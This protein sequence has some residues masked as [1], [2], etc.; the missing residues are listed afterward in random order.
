MPRRL[1]PTAKSSFG[2]TNI[3]IASLSYKVVN[4]EIRNPKSERSPNPE[5][6]I[7]RFGGSILL[8]SGI[9]LLALLVASQCA[10]NRIFR[11]GAAMVDITPTNFPIRTAGNLRLT[12][13]DKAIDPLNVRA[14][15]LD[16]QRIQIAIAVVDSCMID[17]ETM[18]AA[19]SLAQRVTGI[20]VE[21]ML[22]SST[23]TH[24]APA[25]YSCHGN[26]V[27]LAYVQYLIPK[28]AET[29]VQAWRNRTNALVGWGEAD[30]PQ[31][32]HCRHWIMRPG[33]AD[34]PP[35]AFTGQRTNIAMM[36]P[37][38]ANTNKVRQTGVVDSS[39]TVLSLRTTDGRPLAL[40][41]NYS[42]HYAGVG[43]PG[44]SADYFGE[45]CRVIAKDLGTEE[46]K[47]FVALMSNGTSGD[48]NCIDFTKPDWKVD[49]FK[50]ART[51]ADAT[52]RALKEI[53]YYDWVPLGMIE[54]KQ[55]F[56]VRLP[57]PE[58]V[59]EAREFLARKV[60]DRP[61][62]NWEENYA[63]ETMNM[64]DWPRKK[65]VKL[66]AV[67]IGKLGIGTTPCETFGSTGLAIKRNSPFP[68][69]MVIELANGCNGYLPPPDE[70]E[71]GGYT[72]W[73]ARTSYLETGA[74]PEI[75]K[76]VESLLARLVYGKERLPRK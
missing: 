12:I 70:F 24:S 71:V 21:H 35:F 72:T 19:K 10:A 23:H 44:V 51:V 36:N 42:T 50:V 37:G 27:E 69:T 49:R 60:G 53:R 61:T 13:A 7:A 57:R 47:P 74:E 28:I 5:W 32:V 22:I 58:D 38:Y 8:R 33:T 67:C 54:K 25:A 3:F 34:N 63:R 68:V 17:R 16:N 56:K 1:Y 55:S 14:L 48:A 41:A 31:F 75:R 20:P 62:R 9:V 65:E 26:D 45:F 40:L 15:V 6:R 46:A 66:Q 59:A 52:V 64:A 30:C 2:P 73:R 76:S 29:I 43:E 39:V 11:A 4:S 18:D